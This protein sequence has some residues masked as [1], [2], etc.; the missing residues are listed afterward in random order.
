MRFY[1]KKK[2]GLPFRREENIL[3][4]DRFLSADDKFKFM[5]NKDDMVDYMRRPFAKD[6]KFAFLLL[7]I[8]GSLCYFALR[9]VMENQGAPSLQVCAI[10]LSSFLF[11]TAGFYY[12]LKSFKE[13]IARKSLSV[14]TTIVGGV[15]FL[16]WFMIFLSGIRGL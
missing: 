3:D 5:N 7:V 4:S 15:L 9:R 10:G 11:A 1:K 14:F 8:S 12:S 13:G 6:A 16:L 2:M